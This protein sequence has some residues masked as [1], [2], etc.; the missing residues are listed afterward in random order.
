[1]IFLDE[2]EEQKDSLC[3]RIIEIVIVGWGMFVAVFM[4][5]TLGVPYAAYAPWQL[6]TLVNLVVAP[7]LAVLG[8]GCFYTSAEA[9]SASDASAP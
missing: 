9:P 1:M 6:L 5:A 4:I 7:T 2:A 3:L 8:V